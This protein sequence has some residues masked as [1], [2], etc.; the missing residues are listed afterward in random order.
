MTPGI[1][2]TRRAFLSAAGSYFGI[3]ADQL[4]GGSVEDDGDVIVAVLRVALS[5]HDLVGITGRMQAQAEPEQAQE[6]AKSG[7]GDAIALPTCEEVARHPERFKGPQDEGSGMIV[8]LVAEFGREYDAL[9]QAEKAKHGSRFA[10]VMKLAQKA[11]ADYGSKLG[12]AIM[13]RSEK[14]VGGREIAHVDAPQGPDDGRLPESVWVPTSELE[15]HQL[16][17][18]SDTDLPTARS[19]I[20]VAMLTPEQ[21]AK[22][23][24]PYR[25]RGAQ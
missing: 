10:Y 8:N 14:G 24:A 2:S 18:A 20:Q 16:M 25:L 6:G 11:D 7:A 21:K 1:L 19:L 3:P 5:T 15:P 13:A 12:A 22:Y 9:S 17:M 4:V 23:A